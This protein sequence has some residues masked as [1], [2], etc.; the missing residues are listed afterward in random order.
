MEWENLIRICLY[1]FLETTNCKLYS[2]THGCFA[3]LLAGK[4]ALLL[5]HDQR[6]SELAETMG[7]PQRPIE[8]VHAIQTKEDVLNLIRGLDYTDFFA[9][10][11]TNLEKLKHL[12]K[13]CGVET[14]I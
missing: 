9:K 11:I 7:I 13:T 5:A 8:F 3:S 6:T 4:P 14:C 1:F 10:Q 2:V 12:Y